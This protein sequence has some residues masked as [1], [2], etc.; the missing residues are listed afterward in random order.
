MTFYLLEELTKAGDSM[1]QK[2]FKEEIAKRIEGG[3]L[4]VTI[5]L[6]T[7]GFLKYLALE[8]FEALLIN[9]KL[10]L[11]EYLLMKL[12]KSDK[13]SKSSIGDCFQGIGNFYYTFE[14]FEKCLYFYRQALKIFETINDEEGILDILNNIGIV[15]IKQKL[16]LKSIKLFYYI[17]FEKPKYCSAYYNLACI[18]SLQKRLVPALTN[19]KKAIDLEPKVYKKQAMDDSDLDYIKDSKE[20]RKLVMR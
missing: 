6:I 11:E 7:E 2:V 8:E 19:L 12:K 14:R 4:T 1:A 5:F 3:Y 16:Y 17:I 10:N 15:Y 13:K 18:F 9:S 20:F